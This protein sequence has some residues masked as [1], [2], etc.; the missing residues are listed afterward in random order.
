MLGYGQF[1]KHDHIGRFDIRGGVLVDYK[2]GFF[3]RTSVRIPDRVREIGDQAFID[4]QSIEEVI[5]PEGVGRIGKAAFL[6]C[7]NLRHVVMGQQVR[8]IDTGAFS[9]CLFLRDIN[10]PDTVEVIGGNAFASC[11]RMEG[12]HLPAALRQ[13]GP[14]AFSA[15]RVLAHLEVPAG[16]TELG[17]RCFEH[18]FNV[19][20][21]VLPLEVEQ[22]GYDIFFDCGHE[23]PLK[24]YRRNDP[25]KRYTFIFHYKDII[26]HYDFVLD[27][28]RH[29]KYDKSSEKPDYL[30]ALVQLCTTG[31]APEAEAHISIENLLRQNMTDE[32]QMLANAGILVTAGTIDNLIQTC[33]DNKYYESQAFLMQL[34]R[35]RFGY[36]EFE[37]LFTL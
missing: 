23:L 14:K 15:C 6:R 19:E 21:F 8:T 29:Q 7:R 2:P 26:S 36:Q 24:V 32:L 10:L 5:L 33:I 30:N 28:L 1:S 25:Y 22:I 11:C 20:Q 31:F 18:C 16:V 13:I 12:L 9:D 34:K 3:H 27:I 35:D 17:D 37:E 4:C